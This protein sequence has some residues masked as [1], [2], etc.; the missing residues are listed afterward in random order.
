MMAFGQDKAPL[1]DKA[2]IAKAEKTVKDTFK[3]DYKG[4]K[5][6]LAKKLDQV[7]VDSADNPGVRFVALREASYLACEAGDYETGLRA[8]DHIG[9]Y[10]NTGLYALRVDALAKVPQ[11][12]AATRKALA[13][14]GITLADEAVA[15]EEL[16]AAL[17]LATFAENTAKKDR[18]VLAEVAATRSKDIRSIQVDMAKVNAAYQTLQSDNHS[19]TANLIVGKYVCFIKGDWE[20]GLQYLVLGSDEALKT[21]ATKDLAAQEAGGQLPIADSWWD[22]AEK[23]SSIAKM[24]IRAHAITLYRKALPSL[25]G[26]AKARV[27]KRID[28]GEEVKAAVAREAPRAIEDLAGDWTVTN[29]FGQTEHVTIDANGAC[30]STDSKWW[31]GCKFAKR[32]DRWVFVEHGNKQAVV[33]VGQ[34]SFEFPWNGSKVTFKR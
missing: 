10:F 6:T 26:L 18:D 8:V 33:T 3:D 31:N 22:I 2:A 32:D 13:Q 7:G 4:D 5:L 17:K 24:R 23:Q 21:L 9:K 16:D 1:P 27:E 28:G 25:S 11:E 12:N 15:A 30:S 19:K 20:H 29:A 14:R 34:G